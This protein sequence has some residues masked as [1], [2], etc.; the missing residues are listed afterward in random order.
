MLRKLAVPLFVLFQALP[1]S[2]ATS[3][4]ECLFNWVEKGYATYFAPATT[5]QSIA[6]YSLRSYSGTKSYLAVSSNQRVVYLGPLTGN[7]TVDLGALSDWLTLSGCPAQTAVTSQFYD[8][9]YLQDVNGVPVATGSIVDN[10]ANVL[11]SVTFGRSGTTAG[12]TPQ[13]NG[14]GYSWYN[15][16]SYGNGFGSNPGDVNVPAV[17]MICQ[18]VPN[19]GGSRGK[20][21]D[22]LV[23]KSATAIT[24][25][26]SLAGVQFTSYSEDCYAENTSSAVVDSSG[27][28]TFNV[29][30][31]G[32]PERVSLTAAEFNGALSG[33]PVS[34]PGSGA[35]VTFNAYRYTDSQ[36]GQARYVLVEHG[37]TTTTNLSRGYLGIWLAVY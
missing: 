34:P 9:N 23:T 12:F 32:T 24:N 14:N 31:N 21:T 27:N 20:S 7:A 2:A 35:M 3:G 4:S 8:F 25:A 16:I 36:S 5:S 30:N 33:T 28:V 6:G 22:V 1:A 15:P 29:M 26:A 11:G 13:P 18:S 17:A 19:D 37:A 10:G